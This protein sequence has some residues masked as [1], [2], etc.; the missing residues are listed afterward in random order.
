M[1]AFSEMNT[2]NSACVITYAAPPFQ[3]FFIFSR[4]DPGL[5]PWAWSLYIL[6]PEGPEVDRPGRQAGIPIPQKSSAEGAAR[7]AKT[8]LTDFDISH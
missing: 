5:A 3:G 4:P 8:F 7:S 1:T 2:P 6:R